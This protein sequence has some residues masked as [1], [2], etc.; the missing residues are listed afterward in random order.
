VYVVT[1]WDTGLAVPR[2]GAAVFATIAALLYAG[3]QFGWF[4]ML[5]RAALRARKMA[6]RLRAS[7]LINMA[8]VRALRRVIPG[9]TAQEFRR[10]HSSDSDSE[11]SSQLEIRYWYESDSEESQSTLGRNRWRNSRRM[12]GGQPDLRRR[13]SR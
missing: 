1:Q 10:H 7:T 9:N 8:E 3:T 5:G 12:S 2:T 13:Q 4:A 11:S 6:L